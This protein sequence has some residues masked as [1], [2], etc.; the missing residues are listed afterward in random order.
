MMPDQ[1]TQA[2][3]GPA[4]ALARPDW[5]AGN[6]LTAADLRLSQKYIIQRLRRHL[7]LTHG[8]GVVCGLTV[9]SANDGDG[10][11]LLICPGYGIGPC[12][13]EILVQR[14]FRFNMRDFLWTQ[15][16]GVSISRA[17][18]AIE[19]VEDAAAYETAPEISC[20]CDCDGPRELISRLVDGFR[21]VISW[22][23]PVLDSGGFDVC[24]GVTPRCPECP[25]S[26]GLPLASVGLPPVHQSID[27]SAIENLGDH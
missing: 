13:D 2:A 21:V 17:W 11:D 1:D 26:C 3:I 10:W 14:Q 25:A 22:T 5:R 12:G 7:R 6:E 18:I 4:G 16:I 24:S 27:Q 15:P 20:G 19:A 8:W 9:V 23:P